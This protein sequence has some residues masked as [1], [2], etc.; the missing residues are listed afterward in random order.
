[1]K[2]TKKEIEETKALIDKA[3]DQAE[4]S[5]TAQESKELQGLLK[6][7]EI[8]NKEDKKEE[9]KDDF[10]SKVSKVVSETVDKHFNKLEEELKAK[11]DFKK[12]PFSEQMKRTREKMEKANSF[13]ESA[14]KKLE[15]NTAKLQKENE[16]REFYAEYERKY[17]KDTI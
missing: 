8:E 10:S 9:K 2:L 5:L 16:E 6:R 14:S 17:G 7:L 15:A 13:F 4:P 3:L 12:L 11:E 1:M